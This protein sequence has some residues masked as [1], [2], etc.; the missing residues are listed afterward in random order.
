[1]ASQRPTAVSHREPNV[2]PVAGRALNTPGDYIAI[3]PY[4]NNP[5]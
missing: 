3:D 4:R 1:M 5:R 2:D